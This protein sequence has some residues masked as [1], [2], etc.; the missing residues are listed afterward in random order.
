MQQRARK[1]ERK[2]IDRKQKEEKKKRS[3]RECM[4]K[5]RLDSKHEKIGIIPTTFESFL[6]LR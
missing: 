1:S 4:K 3:V 5:N 2:W 6:N